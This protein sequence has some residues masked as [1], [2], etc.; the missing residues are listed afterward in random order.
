LTKYRFQSHREGATAMWVVLVLIVVGILGGVG[1]AFYTSNSIIT[2]DGLL[3]IN[4]VVVMRGFVEIVR[5]HEILEFGRLGVF[6]CAL[7]RIG[8][9]LSPEFAAILGRTPTL[10]RS[11]Q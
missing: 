10:V 7:T 6:Y 8:R 5:L 3:F 11:G 2:T 9:L 1:Y 4:P